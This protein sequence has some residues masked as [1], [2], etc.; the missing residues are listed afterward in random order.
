[1]DVLTWVVVEQHQADV[2]V[3]NSSGLSAW[4][5]SSTSVLPN[6]ASELHRVTRW[7]GQLCLG[8]QTPR[9]ASVNLGWHS[10]SKHGVYV[11][12]KPRGMEWRAAFCIAPQKRWYDSSTLMLFTG[13]SGMEH[14][15]VMKKISR[16]KRVFDIPPG[17][18]CLSIVCSF[19]A[20]RRRHISARQSPHYVLCPLDFGPEIQYC[21]R[22]VASSESVAICLCIRQAAVHWSCQQSKSANKQRVET[23]SESV[24]C[25]HCRRGCCCCCCCCCG[26]SCIIWQM[27]AADCGPGSCLSIAISSVNNDRDWTCTQSDFTVDNDF[28]LTA[29]LSTTDR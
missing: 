13:I 7:D 6:D 23:V 2:S 29:C 24:C 10:S 20:N 5:L 26:C 8:H 28:S 19:I 3:P 17:H 25:R 22:C 14:L 4:S 9:T 11:G 15:N 12:R 21:W 1:M 18:T 27:C 16:L